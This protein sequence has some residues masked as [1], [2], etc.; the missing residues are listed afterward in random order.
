MK[1]I[2]AL[3]IFV[4][5]LIGIFFLSRENKNV[6]EPAVT[7]ENSEVVEEI[8]D[9]AISAAP[10]PDSIDALQDKVFGGDAF[11]V[12][13]VLAENDVYTR[14]YIAYHSEGL[15]ISG[16]MNIPKGGRAVSCSF[17]ESW[18]D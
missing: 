18:M 1:K 11:T 12:G 6:E 15:T 3:L 13:R 4:V 10:H 9:V 2:I 7:I 5:A 14:H 8:S 17:F 16:I